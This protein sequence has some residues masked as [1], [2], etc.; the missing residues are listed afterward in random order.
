MYLSAQRRA[1]ILH[2]LAERGS[3]RSTALARELKV[4]EE[5]IRTDLIALEKQ[6]QLQ[7]I[8]GGALYC[9]PTQVESSPASRLLKPLLPLLAREK[10]IYL[11]DSDLV[12]LLLKLHE[13]SPLHLLTN[14]PSLLHSLQAPAYPHHVASTGGVLDKISKMLLGERALL[15]LQ[16]QPPSCALLCP[17]HISPTREGYLVLH[18]PTVAQTRWVEQVHELSQR[19]YVIGRASM[20][21]IPP[22]TQNY[23]ASAPLEV[24][25]IFSEGSTKPDQWTVPHIPEALSERLTLVAQTQ[26]PDY[27]SGG[28]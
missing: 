7:R 15:N 3:I 16:A 6:G 26:A 13:H 8:H 19:S 23:A 18:Y 14:A 28:Y 10:L 22:D 21:A 12:D 24:T 25:A 20:L 17:H 2:L 5:T 1:Y 4:T 9:I 27:T 11:H